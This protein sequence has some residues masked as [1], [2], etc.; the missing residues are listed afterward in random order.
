MPRLGV[1]IPVLFEGAQ[2]ATAPVCAQLGGIF[3]A[4]APKLPGRVQQGA[5]QGGA[6]VVQQLH[7]LGLNSEAA[8]LDQVT[9]ALAACLRPV[10]GVRA[11]AC[12]IQAVTLYRQAP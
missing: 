12:G 6:V 9:G 3:V 4:R 8:Q 7:Q 2:A 11:G 5:E 10:A 1:P